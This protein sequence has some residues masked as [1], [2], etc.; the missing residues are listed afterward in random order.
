M[1]PHINHSTS[2]SKR[3]D[4]DHPGAQWYDDAGLGLFIHWGIASVNAEVE[5][6]FGMM[7]DKPWD[8]EDDGVHESLAATEI[9]PNEY[10]SL[11][12]EFQPDAFDP[13]KFLRA[14][15]NAGFEYAVLTAKHLAGYTLW[16]SEYSDFGVQ[17]YM[18]GR[19]LVRE[20]VEACRRQGVKAGLYFC[21]GDLSHDAFPGRDDVDPY[22][23]PSFRSYLNDQRPI[24][25]EE[26]RNF[27]TYFTYVKN[28]IGELLTRYGDLDLLWLD[29]PSWFGGANINRGLKEIYETIEAEQPHVVLGREFLGGGD[30]QT[31]ENYLP[32]QPLEGWWEH[33]HVWAP[34]NWSHTETEEYRDMAWTH[35]QLARTVSWG[36]NLLLNVSPR[37]DGS[38]PDQIYDRMASLA[39]WMDHSEAAVKGTDPGPYPPLTDVPVT[40]G[41][42]TWYLH[43][44]QG[45]SGPIELTDVPEPTAVR[46]LRTTDSLEYTYEVETLKI[47][48][49]EE[50][51]AT[52]NE[53]VTVHWD[54]NHHI[55]IRYEEVGSTRGPDEDEE[56]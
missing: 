14:A 41:N 51:R 11:A 10:W 48:L 27:E 37:P 1:E 20:Y 30:M 42:G 13:D 36:G 22:D 33:N 19:D 53:V 34:P 47:D 46:H 43:V 15:K 6:G 35:E 55:P 28:Q 18:D 39:E 8:D 29:V 2:L 56:E 21:M 44:L 7:S 26:L 31:P 32:D 40:R 4:N 52:E 50:L 5:M 23:Y 9:P 3:F 16:P 12:E 49:P 25:D 38:L 54:Q 24:T 17:E 45:H